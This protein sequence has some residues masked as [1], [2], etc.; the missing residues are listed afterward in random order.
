MKRLR[1]FSLL[2]FTLAAL[3]T[4]AV[5]AGDE[6]RTVFINMTNAEDLHAASM[7]LSLASNAQQQGMPVYIFLNV[8]AAKF[9]D[10]NLSKEVKYADFPPVKDMLMK[11]VTQGGT[12]FV[13]SH[14][15]QVVGVAKDDIAKGMI[16]TDHAD[17]LK[18]LPRDGEI[19]SFTY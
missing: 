4:P 3:Q 10:A 15:A 11:I 1:L 16:P 19:L 5:L 7:A 13:C 8:H 6:P 18:K 12:V 2:L 17:F 14:C 9:A